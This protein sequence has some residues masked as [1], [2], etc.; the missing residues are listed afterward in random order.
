MAEPIDAPFS[1]LAAELYN[2]VYGKEGP[3]PPGRGRNG[4]WVL[5]GTV[6]VDSATM[7]ITD[8]WVGNDDNGYRMPADARSATW[9]VMG[10][11]FWCGFG[12]GT[13]EV[14]GWIADYG[15]ADHKDERIAQVVVTMINQ[16]ELDEWSRDG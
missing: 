13:Y 14:W 2:H 6:G 7:A 1:E 16:E 5:L 10:V 4:R 3:K 15:T 11:Q 9:G 8:P 12:D